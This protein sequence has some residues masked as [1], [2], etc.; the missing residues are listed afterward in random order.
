M[1]E[2]ISIINSNTRN[3]KVKNFFVKNK[4]KIIFISLAIII[5]L[6]ATYSFD[7]YKTNQKIFDTALLGYI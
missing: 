5:I 7:K 1:D 3:E 2:E 4:S 6:I